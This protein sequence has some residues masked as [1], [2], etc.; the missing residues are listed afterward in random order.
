[1]LRLLP[2]DADR[3]LDRFEQGEGHEEKRQKQAGLEAGARG[4]AGGERAEAVGRAAEERHARDE[5]EHEGV[6]VHDPAQ[7]AAPPPGADVEREELAQPVGL[8]PQRPE[9]LAGPEA[10]DL[11]ELGAAGGGGL[12][13]AARGRRAGRLSHRLEVDRF[14]TLLLLGKLEIRRAA[15]VQPALKLGREGGQLG[16]RPLPGDAVVEPATFQRG[17]GVM[18]PE[19]GQDGLRLFEVG[20]ELGGEAPGGV[21]PAAERGQRALGHDQ[22]LAHDRD[23][24]GEQFRL[25][26]D[27]GGDDDGRSP[28]SLLAQVAPH[29][30]RGH[31]VEPDRGLVAEEPER[32]VEGGADQRDLLRHA[33][34]IGAEDAAG[35]VC[36]FEA[37]QQLADP[38]PAFRRRHAVDPA[39]VVEVLP[40]GVP[41]VKPGQ[42]GDHAKATA[43]GVQVARQPQ[44]VEADLALV[45]PQDPAQAAQRGRLSRPVLPQKE[46]HL[47]RFDRKIDASHGLHVA[48]AL[49]EPANRN[50]G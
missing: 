7:V 15:C 24:V 27:V 6:Q 18:A 16:V 41:A 38:G 48:E 42:V 10:R 33:S 26:Q 50:H 13:V 43:D 20:A 5:Q 40:G 22:A 9:H 29:V 30:S 44:L 25:A 46:Q 47:P 1:M 35:G 45:G 36:Q 23:P 8:V 3:A 12:S 19:P 32:V 14:Q 37:L 39:V 4:E 21:G 2:P 11:Y 31:R 34:R 28:V 17:L 49:P